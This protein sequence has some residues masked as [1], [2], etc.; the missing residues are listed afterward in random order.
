MTAFV[1]FVGMGKLVKSQCTGEL[2]RRA[3]SYTSETK[4]R[5]GLP[6]LSVKFSL[7]ATRGK[8]AAENRRDAPR[9]LQA[10]MNMLSGSQPNQHRRG[11]AQE[12]QWNGFC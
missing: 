4:Y 8:N 7:D 3:C 1:F 9:G 6:F 10:D 11:V 12:A 2:L 5:A